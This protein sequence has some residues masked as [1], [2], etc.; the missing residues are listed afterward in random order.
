[1]KCFKSDLYYKISKIQNNVDLNYCFHKDDFT[2]RIN[3]FFDFFENIKESKN[4]LDN[5]KND[6]HLNCDFINFNYPKTYAFLNKLEQQA[7]DFKNKYGDTD[8]IDLGETKAN[9]DE[10]LNSIVF[11]K[12]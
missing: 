12:L 1:M 5:Y 3:K 6:N 2:L 11:S 10:C 8:T 4:L 7:T 9:I